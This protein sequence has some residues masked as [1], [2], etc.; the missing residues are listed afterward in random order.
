MIESEDSESADDS[1]DDGSCSEQEGEKDSETDSDV[2]SME[3]GNLQI[4][5]E[6]NPTSIVRDGN[7]FST[8]V[9]LKIVH[10]ASVNVLERMTASELSDCLSSSLKEFLRADHLSS[11]NV[12]IWGMHLLDNG[13]IN[14]RIQ[15]ETRETIQQII[16]LKGWDPEKSLLGSSVSTC[17]VGMHNLK[18][19]NL[20]F[21]TRKE[22]AAIIRKLAGEN[23]IIGHANCLIP[24]IGDIRWSHYTLPKVE[25]VLI[26]DF[27]D[28]EQATEAVARGLRWHGKPH[29]CERADSG[30]RLLRCTRCQGYGH[31]CWGC[32]APHRCGKCAGQHPIA[33]CKSKEVKC[34]S[35]G[36]H[37][38]ARQKGCP[39]KIQA[40]RSLGFLEEIA[41]Q[42]TEPAAKTQV[43]P[44]SPVRHS[45]SAT[46]TQIETCIPSPGTLSAR[47]AKDDIKA[48][49]EQSK[50]GANPTQD[51]Y[52]DTDTLLKR[53]EECSQEINVLKKTV[54]VRDFALQTQSSSQTKRRAG[55]AFGGAEAESSNMAAKRIKQEP[56]TRENSIGLY[57]QP[58]PLLVQRSQ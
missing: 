19:N 58:S 34:A 28:P 30:R 1:T 47:S 4:V 23:D 15:A 42:R 25:A 45:T 38:F 50:P 11:R 39:A 12:H 36:G 46:R 8:T 56:P 29:S 49:N 37:H 54:V 22:K 10:Q 44:S 33:D 7:G 5:R 16:D 6:E 21:Q 52:P 41:S 57:R 2:V 27:I 26:I 13:D 17:K 48:G 32:S 40:R 9:S 3:E 20:K 18:I 35:C 31:L 14:V 24:I 55:E 53:I 51:T 43:S